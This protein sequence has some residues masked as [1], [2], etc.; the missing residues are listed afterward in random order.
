MLRAAG[1]RFAFANE[2]GSFPFTIN[3]VMGVEGS[4]GVQTDDIISALKG[5]IKEGYM[6]YRTVLRASM[7][8][9]LETVS[10]RKRQESELEVAELK[11]LRCGTEQPW[12]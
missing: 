3:D 11:M 7:L 10:L 2:E 4:E 5:H 9:G 8:Y 1:P 6:V 12:A